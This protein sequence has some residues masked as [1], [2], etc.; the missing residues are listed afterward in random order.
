MSPP[1]DLR[2]LKRLMYTFSV[3]ILLFLECGKFLFCS[4]LLQDSYAGIR[5]CRAHMV[6]LAWW[7]LSIAEHHGMDVV[8][9][10]GSGLL[11]SLEVA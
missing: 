9:E 1:S 2:P 3:S 7:R 5:A 4:C 8:R 11:S 6:L 10:V